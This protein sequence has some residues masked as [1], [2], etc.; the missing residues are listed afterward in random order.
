MAFGW[1]LDAMPVVSEMVHPS[2]L[3][4][5]NQRKVVILRDKRLPGGKKLGFKKIAQKVRNLMGQ[6]TTEGMVRRVYSN[7][8]SKKGRVRNN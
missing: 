3:D 1:P 2:G 8:N 6:P 4:F 7:F 5:N